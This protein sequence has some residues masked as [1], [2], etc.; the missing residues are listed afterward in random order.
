MI[1]DNLLTSWK[2]DQVCH[3]LIDDLVNLNDQ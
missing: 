2:K 1:N 3:K